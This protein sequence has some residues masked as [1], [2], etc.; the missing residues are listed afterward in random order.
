MALQQML[1]CFLA[2]TNIHRSLALWIADEKGK[3]H[4]L[5]AAPVNNWEDGADF[6]TNF[7]DG[8]VK[9]WANDPQR[10][11]TWASRPFELQ[12]KLIPQPGQTSF[13]VLDIGAGPVPALGKALTSIP[14]STM[15]LTAT[16]PLADEYKATF[17]KYGITPPI[18]V[19]KMMAEDL[20]V[21]FQANHFD[22]AYSRNALD[23]AKDPLKALKILVDVVKPGR[24]VVIMT[25]VN[26]G[27]ANQGKGFHKW[28]FANVQGRFV[29]WGNSGG[30]VH[31]IG[32]DLAA[33]VSQVQCNCCSQKTHTDMQFMHPTLLTCWITKKQ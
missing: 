27:A 9:K 2:A 21:H 11:K 33:S 7:W 8:Q 28:N 17:S 19:V 32:A 24:N 10:L 15:N 18:P 12:D 3:S 26:E 29:L 30:K 16:D 25:H 1:L 23:H 20:A 4:H 5:Q 22:L 31:D 13:N 14:G 6:E